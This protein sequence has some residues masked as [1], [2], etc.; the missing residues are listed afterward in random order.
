MT[1][2]IL[3]IEKV[4]RLMIKLFPDASNWKVEWKY[5]N[6]KH[7]DGQYRQVRSVNGRITQFGG[8]IANTDEEDNKFRKECRIK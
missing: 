6:K 2:K 4:E 5:D 7:E 3:K 1:K 8:H